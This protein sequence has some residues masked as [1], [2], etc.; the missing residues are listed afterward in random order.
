MPRLKSIGERL[1]PPVTT[2]LCRQMQPTLYRYVWRVSAPQQ[3]RLAVLAVCLF[4]LNMAPLELQRLMVN[5]AIENGN[6]RALAWL[7]AVYLAVIVLHAL[8]KYVFRVYQSSVGEG[9]VRVL[10]WRITGNGRKADGRGSQV[11][12]AASES[13]QVGGF[14]GEAVSVPLLQLGILV[15]VLGYMAWLQ[16][17]MAGVAVASIIPSVVLTPILQARINR[18][19]DSRVRLMRR[20]GDLYTERR[21][22]SSQAADE[23]ADAWVERIYSR[24]IRIFLLKFL[25]KGVNNLIGAAGPLGI[26]VVGGYFVINGATEVGTI[27]AFL[28]GFERLT[29]PARELLNFYRRF[30]QVNT[31]FRLLASTVG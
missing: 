8:L 24:R 25:L 2:S 9:V 6:L 26:L 4:P 31:Q 5:E 1:F 21:E 11:A 13:E 27:V 28:S 19:I 22:P 15:T 3:V 7:G 20:V 10:R 12:L 14:V 29:S 30:S 16:P 18:H 17:V 23:R